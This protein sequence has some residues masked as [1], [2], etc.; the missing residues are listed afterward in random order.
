MCETAIVYR[1][2]GSCI[3]AGT[4]GE[5]RAALGGIE[6]MLETQF[7]HIAWCDD[8]CLCRCDFEATAE[9]ARMS[10]RYDCPDWI[11]EPQDQA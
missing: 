11:I 1:E 8:E 10:A 2:D 4:K 9:A 5:L 3:A 7:R 6:P